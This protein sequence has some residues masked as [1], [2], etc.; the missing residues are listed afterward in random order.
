MIKNCWHASFIKNAYI[1]LFTLFY[2]ILF[3]HQWELFASCIWMDEFVK[4][5]VEM[6]WSSGGNLLLINTYFTQIGFWAI[7]N[8]P[9][10]LIFGT[11]LTLQLLLCCANIL[12]N[13][14]RE[15]LSKPSWITRHIKSTRWYQSIKQEMISLKLRKLAKHCCFRHAWWIVAAKY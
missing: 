10:P 7:S 2:H 11:F 3:S 6:K 15:T 8:F 5:N 9:F 14:W 13:R 12:N 1:L 4:V